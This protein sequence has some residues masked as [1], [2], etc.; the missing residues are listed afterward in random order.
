MKTAFLFVLTALLNTG[1]LALLRRA[2]P[3]V[4]WVGWLPEVN[5]RG[6]LFLLAGLLAYAV[7][8]LLTV[9]I[10]SLARFG[11]AVPLFVALQ[12]VFSLLL[13]HFAFDEPMS[14]MHW[15]GVLLILGGVAM[16]S[17]EGA[18]GR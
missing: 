6:L 2:G 10:L 13:A 4:R 15:V 12:F 8:F 14:W 17:G 5:L 18:W 3:D 7:A 9:R 11:M 16:I 1:A